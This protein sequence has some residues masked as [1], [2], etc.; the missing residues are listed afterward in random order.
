MSQAEVERE[1]AAQP[2]ASPSAS[3]C[4]RRHRPRR[5]RRR[6]SRRRVRS[7]PRAGTVVARC[8]GG[9][10]LIV[11]MSP[12]QGFEVHEREDGPQDDGAEGEFRGISDNHDRVKIDVTCADRRPEIES[13][14]RRRQR[15]LTNA[16]PGRRARP[17]LGPWTWSSA[18]TAR[19]RRRCGCTA[20][21]ARPS[22]TAGCR[23]GTGCRPPGC[24]PPTWGGPQQRG[25]RVRTAGRRGLS[26][27]RGSGR[28]RSSRRC[29]RRPAPRRAAADPLRPRAG[30]D[31]DAAAGQFGR[32]RRRGTTSAPASRTPQL[33][34]FDTWRRLVAAE[35]RLRA[36]SPGT[37]AEPSGHPAL[38]AAIAR[39]LGVSRSIRVDRRR[40]AGHQRHPARARPDRPGAAAARRR[41]GRR[42]ARLSARPAA[43]R[44]ARRAGGRRTGGWR[45]VWS[46]TRCRRTPGWSTRRRRTSSR[47]AAR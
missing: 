40:R 42:G 15:R 34:P 3:R 35:V 30:W 38:R 25:H 39:Y 5:R 22:W 18:W 1:L 41:G 29:G 14:P 37:Y 47:S 19:A 7:P 23:P 32:R 21:C 28:A 26:V 13:R 8:D 24:W 6:P 12:A 46:S 31:F 16:G 36:N 17:G 2:P 43:V 4:P 33:F 10:A 27:R 11:S 44:V 45:R 20:P 9:A